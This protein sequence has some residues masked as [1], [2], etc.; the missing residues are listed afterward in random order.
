[1]AGMDEAVAGGGSGF[2]DVDEDELTA[3]RD[4]LLAEGDPYLTLQTM[5]S[6]A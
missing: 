5:G 4:R 3:W 6:P 1:M 2:A